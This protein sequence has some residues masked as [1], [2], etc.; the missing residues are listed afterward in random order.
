MA[1]HLQKISPS[2]CQRRLA[3]SNIV[4]S[5]LVRDPGFHGFRNQPGMTKKYHS[6]VLIFACLLGFSA[7]SQTASDNTKKTSL[8]QASFWFEKR[9]CTH[10]I[11]IL[12][13]KKLTEELEDESQFVQR[14][15]M[16]GVC[17]FQ[18]GNKKNAETEFN[19][20]L[21]IQPN[22]ELDPFIT[23]PPLLDLFNQLKNNIKAKSQELELAKEKAIDKPQINES[24]TIYKKNS[25]IP[26]FA[27]FGLG[28]FQ[29][30]ETTK[31]IILAATQISML[32]G[33]IG[34][35]WW[36]RSFN[37]TPGTNSTLEQYNLAQTLQFAALGVFLAV[38]IYSVTDAI[39][40]MEPESKELPVNSA[41]DIT[42]E[43][44]LQEF[45]KAKNN[46]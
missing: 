11:Q 12:N 32:S 17:Y 28:Q 6:V 3:S 41:V 8:K 38:Y 15:H 1:F 2:S 22:F 23:P 24:R 4:I 21:F 29:N 20:L 40:N 43:A 19:E 16:L 10:V 13:E 34:F 44:F 9:N 37:N 39:L 18:L 36:K 25:I 30:G 35:Y 5:H 27:P 7:F 42:T 14:Y 33:N 46:F 26:A 45:K 31:G